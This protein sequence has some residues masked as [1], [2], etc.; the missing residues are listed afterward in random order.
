VVVII[1]VVIT[2][3]MLRV[4]GLVLF[5]MLVPRSAV[6]A[7]AACCRGIR[8]RFG[9]PD[10]LARAGNWFP[11]LTVTNVHDAVN[12]CHRTLLDVMVA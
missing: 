8:E 9:L 11:M 5:L 7:L 2:S 4:S 6:I 1:S 10:R 12:L 3:A